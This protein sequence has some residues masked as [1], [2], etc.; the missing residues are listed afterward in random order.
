MRTL[1]ASLLCRDRLRVDA[2]KWIRV[3]VLRMVTKHLSDLCVGIVALVVLSSAQLDYV[4]GETYSYTAK[5]AFHQPQQP[6]QSYVKQCPPLVNFPSQCRPMAQCSV[7]WTELVKSPQSICTPPNSPQLKACCPSIIGGYNRMGYMDEESLESEMLSVAP[8]ELALVTTYGVQ[9]IHRLAV[10]EKML[11]E[12]RVFLTTSSPSFGYYINMRASEIAAAAGE[13]GLMITKAIQKLKE[14]MRLSNEAAGIATQ[15]I[16]ITGT[17][18]EDTCL[19]E[20]T[21]KPSKYRTMDGSCNNLKSPNMGRSVTQLGRYK[22]PQYDD[23]VW[24]ARDQHMPNSRLV[25]VLIS[26]DQDDFQKET[27]AL[28]MQFGQFVD[29]DITHVPV[30]QLANATGISCCTQNGKHLPKQMRHPHCFTLDI[31]PNDPFY[32]QYGVECI[33]FVRSMVAPRS[34]CK[35]GYA[36]QLNQ[37]THWHD[38]ST[39]YGSNNDVADLLREKR[40]GRLKTF[41]YQGRQ[42]LPLD[43]QNKDCIGYDKGLRCFMA[44]DSR[45]NQ[46]IGL[47]AMHTLF[48]RE[49][50]RLADELYHLNPQWNDEKLFQEARRILIALE[51]HITYNEYLPVLLGRSVM[52]AYGLLPKNTGYYNSYNEN[53]TATVFN[54]FSTAAYRYGHSMVPHWFELVDEKGA[55]YERMHLGDYFNNPHP[56]LKEDIFDGVL[57]GLVLSAPLASDVK[58]SSEL[59]NK[60]L[61]MRGEKYGGDLVAFNVWR[62]R[63]HGLP[64]YNTYR[65]LFGLPKAKKFTDLADV[66]S[67]DVIEKLAALYKTPDDIDLFAAGMAEKAFPGSILGHTFTHM[68]A[69]QFARLKAGDRFYYEN[70]GQSGSFTPDQLAEIRKVS[71]ASVICRNGDYIQHMQ[72]L[73]FRPVTNINPRLPCSAI[74]SMSL[75]PWKE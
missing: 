62:G 22:A 25:R 2:G 68:I 30:F 73:A 70:G 29:H 17:A 47:T 3:S 50:N 36:E 19:P 65:E 33:N 59:T 35:F 51:Q 32:S 45:A 1:K 14:R 23:G 38:A 12:H 24:E 18:L 13:K 15:H 60:L 26:P 9:E 4:A 7:W 74:P 27:T 43:W 52:E 42:L 56:M 28:L 63:D 53:I 5:I 69:D 64:G 49:H 71:M 34:D 41:N 55:T 6:Q 46:L 21:C 37:V 31:L 57:R 16:A 66:L 11:V 61:K 8:A 20:P 75:I 72:P 39:I 67:P 10:E 48:L 44:G 54:E 58:F 40:G